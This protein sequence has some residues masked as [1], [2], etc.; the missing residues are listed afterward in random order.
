MPSVCAH[1]LPRLDVPGA[2]G[3]DPACFQSA[4]SSVW[5]PDLSPRETKRALAAAIRFSASAAFAPL[6]LAGSSR[7]ADHDE[8]VIHDEAAVLHLAL[9]DVL[10][11]PRRRMGERHVGLAARGQGQGLAGADRDRLD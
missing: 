3:L 11:L 10:L 6:I 1:A 5:V 2:L 8:V 4:S 7:G 9:V